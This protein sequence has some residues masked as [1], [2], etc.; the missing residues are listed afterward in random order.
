[1]YGGWL[2]LRPRP[3]APPG[4]GGYLPRF[5]IDQPHANKPPV[6]IDALDL[7]SVQLELA[8]DGGREVNP[9]SVQL[10]KSDRLLAG[11]AQ[12]PQQPLLLSVS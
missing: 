2:P 3:P 6:L 12:A 5:W 8:D 1:V 10:S 4:C 7:I 9:A 11:L